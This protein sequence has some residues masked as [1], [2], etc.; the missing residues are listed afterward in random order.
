MELGTGGF[1]SQRAKKV[2]FTLEDGDNVFR[3]LPALGNLAAKNIWSKFY[4][5]EFGYYDS[6]GKMKVFQCPRVVNF[7]TKMVEVESAA[8]LKR[9]KLLKARDLVVDFL[10]S[11]PGD[12][13]KENEREKLSGLLRQFNSDGKFYVNAMDLNGRIGLL[14][15][16]KTAFDDLK[17]EMRK[18]NDAGTNPLA[19]DTGRFFVINKTGQLRDTAYKVTLFKEQK[20]VALPDGTKVLASIDVVHKLT[21]DIISRLKEEA[22]KLDEIYP[23][24]SPEQVERI[25]NGEAVDIVIPYVR[26]ESQETEAKATTPKTTYAQRADNTNE[27]EIERE[28]AE[29]KAS[30]PKTEAKAEAARPTVINT[31]VEE[32]K[33]KAA[34]PQEMDD[35][36]ALLAQVMNG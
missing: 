11:N 36:D 27:E 28:V 16:G 4:R 19:A 30:A 17:N 2:Y 14:K 20:E 13:K 5:V 3:I 22:F 8:Y 25:V 24:V 18:L 15:L 10:K 7:K 35:I 34:A 33:E 9:E 26:A 12:Q 21:S 1:E 23:Y 29:I 32:K 31:P 6:K